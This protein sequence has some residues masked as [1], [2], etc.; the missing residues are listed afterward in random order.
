MFNSKPS[1][2]W[3]RNGQD[4]ALQVVV[5]EEYRLEIAVSNVC[6]RRPASVI[7]EWGMYDVYVQ[8]KYCIVMKQVPE[9]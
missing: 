7:V 8:P 2:G 9:S 5:P 1:C 6:V 4:K 3:M